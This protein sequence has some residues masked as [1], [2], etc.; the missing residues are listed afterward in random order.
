MRQ[1]IQ[2]TGIKTLT[3]KFE[4]TLS[5][6]YDIPSKYWRFLIK[7]SD[8]PTTE[9]KNKRKYIKLLNAQSLAIRK[10]YKKA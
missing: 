8:Q 7:F 5:G 3:I 1:F 9:L 2:I 4:E 10:S 6:E